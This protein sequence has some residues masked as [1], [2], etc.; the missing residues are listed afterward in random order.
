MQ[1]IKSKPIQANINFFSDF[2]YHCMFR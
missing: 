1:L 2:L